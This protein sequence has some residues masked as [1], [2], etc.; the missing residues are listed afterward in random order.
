MNDPS[1]PRRGI[2]WGTVTS[3]TIA[4]LTVAVL[5]LVESVGIRIPFSTAGPGAIIV[6]GVLILVTGLALVLRSSARDRRSV[7]TRPVVSVA[8]APAPASAPAQAPLDATQTPV[9]GA[10]YDDSD[11]LGVAA[12][13]PH[14]TLTAEPTPQSRDLSE[15][16]TELAADPRATTEIPAEQGSAGNLPGRGRPGG[17]ETQSSH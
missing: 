1:T 11:P 6:V 9:L 2:A 15:E 17:S 10:R 7:G 3:G 14:P 8:P 12:S 16:T 4:L 13:E 5:L